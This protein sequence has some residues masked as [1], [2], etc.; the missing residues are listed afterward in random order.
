MKRLDQYILSRFLY[1]FTSSFVILMLIFVFQ[2]IWIFIDEFAG[3]GLD[4]IIIG[5][6]L[7]YYSPTL[8]NKVLPL[9]VLLSSI[10]TFG[11]FAENYEFAAMKA[12]GISLQRAMR[13]LIVFVFLLGIGTFFFANNVIPY[14]E[15]KSYNLRKN[16]AKLKPALAINEGVFNDINNINIKVDEKYGD[17]DKFLKNV[18][19]HK[20]TKNGENRTVIKAKDGELIS[21]E[22]SDVL[23]LVL[24][25]GNYYEDVKSSNPRGNSKYPHAKV[26]FKTYTINVDL[27]EFNK[28]DIGDENTKNRYKMLN[29][30]QLSY[31][32]DSI[33][34][35]N[36]E[37]TKGF[38][39]SIYRRSGIGA[40]NDKRDTDEGEFIEKQGKEVVKDTSTQKI[41][42]SDEILLLYE[43]WRRVSLISAAL[44]N[45]TNTVATIE[46]K[47]REL[48]LRDKLLNLHIIHL[49]AKYALP[50]ACIILFFIGAPLGAIVRKGGVGLPMVLAIGLF[51]V[52]YFID[53]FARNYSEDGSISPT[54]GP[55][56]SALIMLPL[57]IKLTQNATA[58][59]GVFDTG[60]IGQR[61]RNLFKKKEPENA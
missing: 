52:Y 44:S 30:N 50:F 16:I 39:K 25:D 18:I 8:V 32:I 9:T 57:S 49:N 58:D 42:S 20:K 40:F 4:F 23:E 47:K 19:I 54:I 41:K 36:I 26:N 2:A 5:K 53:L 6:F 31:F 37:I 11:S 60:N 34:D 48:F 55:W 12:S 59:K 33:G 29:V 22:E 27:R 10:M 7:F 14:A 35:D 38:G 17:N 28:V 21:S 13:S 15:F 45:I 24:K 46:G 56:I 3:K 51:L 1:N 61:F 43:D